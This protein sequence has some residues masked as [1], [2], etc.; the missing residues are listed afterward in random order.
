M[1]TTW[2]NKSSGPH[3]EQ[4][5]KGPSRR[6]RVALRYAACEA[7]FE[8]RRFASLLRMRR[9]ENRRFAFKSA[10]AFTVMA[11]CSAPA[12]AQD[13]A[14]F[15]A[16]K[17][18]DFII[19]SA[20]GGGYYVYAMMLS[21]HIGKHI[22]GHPQVVARL[23]EGAGSL[24][25]ANQLYSRLPADG[26]VF[27]AVFT[28]AI[29]EPLIGDQNKARYDSRRFGYVGSANRETS[30]C[31]AQKDAGFKNWQDAL[32]RKLIVGGA[33][34]AS[35]IRQFPAVLNTII[36]AK[37]QII[38]GYPG[39]KEAVQAVEKN[40]VQG[41]CG[42]QLSSFMPTNG[43]WIDSGY[44]K[45]FGQIAAAGGDPSLNKMGVQNIWEVVKNPE[46]RGVLELIFN[47]SEFGRPYIT[48]PG[49]PAD[50]L[51]ALRDAFD[52]TMKDPEFLAEAE[53]AKLPIDPVS[54]ADFAAIVDKL[55]QVPE[56]L[57]ARARKALE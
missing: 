4:A 51:K 15:Y 32:D 39:S 1:L 23:M 9:P 10:V 33:G 19:G 29:V 55:Y 24:T 44:V 38:T 11:A 25:A 20:A 5:P 46:D 13:P 22:P 42:I 52:A 35:S 36:G 26:T 27:G 21:R 47:Q 16:G 28:G 14:A 45:V 40:E 37:F 34:W 8:T 7:S 6:T 2:P 56:A 43:A 12:R 57:A 48:P 54:G 49:V 50:R 17:S 30:I 53:K 31:F 41:I 3:P 18:V